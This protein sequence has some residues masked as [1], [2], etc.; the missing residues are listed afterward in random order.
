MVDREDQSVHE[1]Q[2]DAEF[3]QLGEAQVYSNVTKGTVYDD[4]KRLA[5]FRWLAERGARRRARELRS[6]Q[7]ATWALGLAIGAVAVVI[8]GVIAI[9]LHH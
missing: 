3:E 8:F 1:A 7:I 9:R 6:L 2:W 5:A 4:T